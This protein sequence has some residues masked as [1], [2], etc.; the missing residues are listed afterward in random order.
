MASMLSTL[1]LGKG[2][3]NTIGQTT[4]LFGQATRLKEFLAGGLATSGCR[5]V[6][7]G[8]ILAGFRNRLL[9]GGDDM[10]GDQL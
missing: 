1:G 9:Y 6:F 8:L 4:L 7:L 10:L 3:R 5:E 2:C